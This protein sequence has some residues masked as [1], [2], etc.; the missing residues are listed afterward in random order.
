MSS[1]DVRNRPHR[2]RRQ[3]AAPARRRFAV[4]PETRAEEI[5]E[6]IRRWAELHGEPPTL[7]DWEPSRAVARGQAWR[8]ER[9]RA[10][11]WPTTRVVRYHFGMMGAAVAAAGLRPR[12]RPT[13]VRR[14][15]RSADSV[16]ESIRSWVER[17]GE[18]P[19]MA[20]WD[21]PRARAIGQ[22]W[23]VA[24]FYEGD[25]PNVATVRHHFGTLNAAVQKAGFEPRPR[26]R[27][28]RRSTV[29]PPAPAAHAD[30]STV[31]L[32]VRAVGEAQRASDRGALE[33]ALR[34]LSAACLNWADRLAA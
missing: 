8:L 28:K 27:R 7:A 15:L 21:P 19:G 25:W 13:R 32:R 9:F 23:R 4:V 1:V 24:R 18:T 12:R 34:D 6:A 29:P 11:E 22:M 3:P 33:G 30:A 31:V 5:L 26:G 10:G 16:L 14:P 2:V 17:Y 20:D